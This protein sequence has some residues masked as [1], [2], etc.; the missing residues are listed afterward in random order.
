MS[1]PSGA[2]PHHPFPW[3]IT[4]LVAVIV[5]VGSV[6]AGL[7]LSRDQV[8][9]T[10]PPGR[11][12]ATPSGTATA[13]VDQQRQL[14]LLL[15]VRDDDR[16]AVS[17]LLVGAGGNAETVSELLLPRDLL[18]PTVPPRRLSAIDDPTGAQSAEEPLETLLGVQV[19]AI[20]DLDRLAWAGLIDATGSR[21]D[22]DAAEEPGSFGLVVDRVL[23]G[24]PYEPETVGELL[25]GLGSMA[26]TTVTNE[27][28]SALLARTGRDLRAR[29]VVRRTLPVTYVRAGPERAA[30]ADIGQV[31]PLMRE[32]F[33]EALL[34]PGH[35]GQVRV[36]LQPAGATLGAVTATRRT[37]QSAGLGVVT[38]PVE[39]ELAPST[40]ILVPDGS[41]AARAAGVRVADALGLP[42]TAVLVDAGGTVDVRVL[43]GPDV[44]PGGV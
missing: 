2:P 30:V 26:R 6:V 7:V 31:E 39:Q 41:E 17:S 27:E 24:L 29:D 37:L 14:T 22:V 34:E 32:L 28:V 9:T 4:A 44:G 12:S 16:S 35:P 43:L 1:T 38:D 23:K 5:L 19:D 36:V 21:V 15:I 42:E 3:R 8:T 33:P 13:L 10:E 20:L 25:T 18:L 40:V 11:P